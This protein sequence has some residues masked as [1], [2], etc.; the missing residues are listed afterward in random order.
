MRK[1]KPLMR[2]PR[3]F[4]AYTRPSSPAATT[5]GRRSPA[6]LPTAG[7]ARMPARTLPMRR[8]AP[9]L[10]NAERVPRG[11]PRTIL[12][13]RPPYTRTNPSLVA[14][15]I[16]FSLRPTRFASTGEASPE[17]PRNLG[18]PRLSWRSLFTKKNARSSPELPWAS[19]LRSRSVQ[20]PASSRR[21]STRPSR[22]GRVDAR[23]LEAGG[24]TL[25]LRSTDAQ[26][27][28]GEDRA[29]FF[30]N[31]DRQLKRGFPRFLGS[32]GEASPVLANL[33]G[34]REKE[35]VLATSDGLVRVYG[36]RKGRM[37]RGW[38]ALSP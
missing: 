27:N 20:P 30:V 21:A 8:A 38:P 34:R 6:M 19:V 4:Q 32:S 17:L 18:K 28:S 22:R 23:R 31:S 15:T 13:L 35:I 25:R 16:S 37:V 14:S 11:H 9:A 33:V 29:F 10:A 5:S 26:G 24:W 1:G 7:V 2:R 12:P 36:G 3:R